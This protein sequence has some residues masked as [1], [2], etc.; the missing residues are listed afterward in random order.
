MKKILTLSSLIILTSIS[1]TSCG[2]SN[3]KHEAKYHISEKVIV[4]KS[5]QE[6]QHDLASLINNRYKDGCSKRIRESC[7][8]KC[9]S[10]VSEY[11]DEHFRNEKVT[12]IKNDVFRNQCT[13]AF[14]LTIK[15]L[16]K[17][18][19]P[20]LCKVAGPLGEASATAEGF[21]TIVGSAEPYYG[22]T[23]DEEAKDI[24]LSDSDLAIIKNN[25][26]SC[27]RLHFCGKLT[28]NK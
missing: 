5:D 6:Y 21:T 27:A 11:F 20:Q 16:A 1:L 2:N 12:R 17:K 19:S 15:K 23:M 3:K 18:N 14:D 4:H 22:G 10:M 7:A 28:L 24:E 25:L 13:T 26:R 9:A 8:E